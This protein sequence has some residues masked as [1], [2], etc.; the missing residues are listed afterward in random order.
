M[1]L[2]EEIEDTGSDDSEDG[3]TRSKRTTRLLWLGLPAV[4]SVLLLA[5]TNQ[6]SQDVAV[7]PFLWVLPLSL[8]LL[9]FII[10]FDHDKWYS[11][12]VFTLALIPAM[13]GVE[14][15]KRRMPS[16]SGAPL[17]HKIFLFIA[18]NLL[19]M[20]FQKGQVD[21]APS[22]SQHHRVGLLMESE[23]R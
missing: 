3:P 5:V 7:I 17:A 18:L 14:L 1:Q 19:Q 20:N 12:T 2:E 8:Y 23:S 11:R 16:T 10:A 13:A 15:R 21:R 22:G 4:A 9:S 6:M